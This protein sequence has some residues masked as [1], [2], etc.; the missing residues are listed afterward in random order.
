MKRIFILLALLLGLNC[1]AQQQIIT[2]SLTVTNSAGTANTNTITLNGVTRNFTNYVAN[3]QTSILASNSVWAA[4]S[5]LF[6]GYIL[7]APNSV[8]V[9]Q[10]TVSNV[11]YMS[12]PN[13]G[14]TMSISP[15]WGTLSWFTNSITNSIV[16]RVPVSSVGVYDLTNIANGLRDY[17]NSPAVTNAF[18]SSAPAFANF[19]QLATIQAYSLW[20]TNFTLLTSNSLKTFALTIGNQGTNFSMVVSNYFY[21]LFNY[22]NIPSI[23]QGGPAF[24]PLSHFQSGSM[25]LSNLVTDYPLGI[26]ANLSYYWNVAEFGG[27]GND[28]VLLQTNYNNAANHGPN[29]DPF[30][31]TGGDSITRLLAPFG[32]AWES[33]Y[34]DGD[35]FLEADTSHNVEVYDHAGTVRWQMFDSG[36]GS[37]QGGNYWSGSGNVPGLQE[38][39]NGY[40][41]TL[42]PMTAY[43]GTW[44]MVLDGEVTN[45]TAYASSLSASSI[46]V[47]YVQWPSY[48]MITNGDTLTRT[49]GIEFASSSATKELQI[50]FNGSTILDTGAIANTGGS[51]GG[52]NVVCSLTVQNNSTP[53]SAIVTYTCTAN[54]TGTASGTLTH[55]A[56]TTVDLTS[57]SIDWHLSLI[58]GAGGSNGDEKVA[59]D[60]V[61]FKPASRRAIAQ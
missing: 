14:L 40:V 58:T 38:T 51:A 9:S 16:V 27:Y 3:Y 11:Q 18:S 50:N 35:T 12:Y 42:Q 41:D 5:N 39:A 4:T 48:G 37:P 44:P 45:F 25:V 26:P 10:T 2:A 19:A 47:D 53:S 31:G 23:I 60:N 13:A 15:G 32:Q 57:G 17:L 59:M 55:S 7:Y 49:I 22:Y 24:Y 52:I 43:T 54:W 61:T 33:M 6:L 20:N 56:H 46:A 28:I 30:A 8:V 1:H 36:G 29:Y 21:N 34:E